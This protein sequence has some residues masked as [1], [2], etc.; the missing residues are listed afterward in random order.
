MRVDQINDEHSNERM[1][2]WLFCLVLPPH[3]LFFNHFA[4]SALIAP[5]YF[6]LS[7]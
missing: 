3:P 5:L 6:V 2:G 7:E 4:R 1:H